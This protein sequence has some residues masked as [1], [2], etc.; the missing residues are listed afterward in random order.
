MNNEKT[1]TPISDFIEAYTDKH[2]VRLHMPGHKGID[3]N[4]KPGCRALSEAYS[5]D[6]TEIRGADSLYESDI[7]HGIIYESELIATRHFGSAHTFYSTEG[8]SQ[9]IKAMC[10]LA[11]THYLQAHT[12]STHTA[13]SHPTGALAN[14]E[15]EHVTPTII[16]GRNAHK[17]FIYASQLLRFNIDWLTDEAGDSSLLSC[18]ITPA[19]LRTHLDSLISDSPSNETGS[20]TLSAGY[21]AVYITSPDYLGNILDIQGLAEVCHEYGLQLLV[22]N[23][24]GAYL[25]L[26]PQEACSG[27]ASSNHKTKHP[28]ALGADIVTDSAH[29][30]LPVLTGG[31]YLHISKGCDESILHSVHKSMELFGSTSPSYLILES[32]DLANRYIYQTCYVDETISGDN[33]YIRAARQVQSL[34]ES[35]RNYGFKLAG[36]EPLKLSVMLSGYG[37]SY[38]TLISDTMTK[39]HIEYE[40]LD[41]DVL[42]LMFSP[43]NSAADFERLHVVMNELAPH[44]YSEKGQDTDTYNSSADCDILSAESIDDTSRLKPRSIRMDYMLPAAAKHTYDML[45]I[46]GTELSTAT[47]EPVGRI[48]VNADIPCP[49]AV[50]PIVPGE[51]IDSDALML[52]RRYNITTV[53]VL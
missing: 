10:S 22:D 52:L 38:I 12:D 13:D 50:L 49:P 27:L 34:K 43:Q 19:G 35:L 24:H 51:V 8:S 32:L 25:S 4:S 9:C 1:F 17:S 33:P 53:H 11:I 14:S 7:T 41:S 47:D 16:A 39:H 18:R 21:C 2:P 40:Y 46:T 48:L 36:N 5:H 6:I 3:S 44:M 37:G 30:T 23:A 20:H 42:I 31:A 26:F 29:K 15:S 28:I 45:S